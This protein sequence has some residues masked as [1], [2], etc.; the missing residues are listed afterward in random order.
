[1]NIRNKNN[2]ISN[3]TLLLTFFFLSSAFE[4][5]ANHL[6]VNIEN[7]IHA[8]E[9]ISKY[10][11][12]KYYKDAVRLALRLSSE[13]KNYHAL[14]AEVPSQ[15][16]SS[17]YNALV[18]VHLN[19]SEGAHAVTKTHKMHTFP[20]PNV[21]R[22]FVVYEKK[23]SW[24]KPLRLGNLETGSEKVNKLLEKYGLVI[25]RNS[26]WDEENNALHIRAKEPLN[27]T[28]LA[29]D[30]K[31]IDGVILVD[32]LQP[33]GEGN[34]IEIKEI[35]NGWQIDY[36]LKFDSCFTGCQK[37]HYWSF[38]VNTAG[39]VIYLGE[40]GDELPEWMQETNSNQLAEGR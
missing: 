21:D 5:S 29:N 26:E 19:G 6:P 13:N 16:V 10:Q 28:P 32:L 33:D 17:I 31:R 39:D 7:P 2:Q 11:Q 18:A 22:F 9:T 14:K 4:I 12:K 24:A 8:R 3:L 36:V 27:I 37:K 23:A 38:Q 35:E 1:M 15:L 20:D 30:F 40:F 25:D 34:D